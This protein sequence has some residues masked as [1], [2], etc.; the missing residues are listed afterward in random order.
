[1]KKIL[2]IGITIALL[3]GIQSC[4]VHFD[5]GFCLP[6]NG[7]IV[8]QDFVLSDFNSIENQTVI[9]VEVVQGDEQMVTVEGDQ[10]IIDQLELYVHGN[11]LSIDLREGCYKNFNLKIYVT[12]PDLEQVAVKSTGNVY[13][14][15]FENL[16]NL[17][18]STSST[19]DIIGIGTLEVL[20]LTELKTS[21]TGNIK[22]ELYTD[23]LIAEMSS[24]GNLTL[25]GSCSDQNIEMSGTGNYKAYDF[26]SETC[27][28][29][30]S[31]TGDA[32]VNVSD[33]LTAR[34]SSVGNVYYMGS[35]VL[36]INDNGVGDLIQVN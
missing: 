25:V 15:D 18:L 30:V 27:Y 13:I 3:A 20:N 10:N 5:D 1:M 16:K 21:S 29:K 2:L 22:L 28:V 36:S 19:G 12:I 6:G 24:T 11:E 4:Y 9:D 7:N 14:N 35:P 17:S 26:E 34:I 33:K 32:K 8:S 31:G 23:N